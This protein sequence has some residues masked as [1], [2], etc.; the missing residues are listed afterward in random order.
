MYLVTGDEVLTLKKCF[1]RLLRFGL[2]DRLNDQVT[3]GCSEGVGHGCN[4]W[5]Q[6]GG[7]VKR[8]RKSCSKYVFLNE[9]S[10]EKKEGLGTKKAR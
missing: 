5:E 10:M 8:R 1:L 7:H 9:K 3:M 2:S 6:D 4:F